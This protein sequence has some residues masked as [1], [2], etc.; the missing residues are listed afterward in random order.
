MS[1]THNKIAREDIELFSTCPPSNAVDRSNYIRR[2]IEAAR[3]S[4]RYGAKGI[5]VYT[6]NALI[7]PWLVA[8]LIVQ[9]TESQCPLIAVQPVYMHPYT[10]AKVVTSFGYLYGRRVYLNMVAGG[11]KNDLVALTDTTPHDRRYD[12][13]VEYTLIIKK[14]LTGPS[15]VSYDGEFYK[16]DNLTLTPL[17]HPDLFPRIF[18][19][20]S[21]EAGLAAAKAIDAVAVEYPKP[22]RE[23]QDRVLDDGIEHGIRVGIIARASTDDAW[24]VAKARFPEDR[25]GQLTHQLAMKVSDSI[26]HKQLSQMDEEKANNPYWLGPFHNYKTFCPYLVGSYS[27]VAAELSRYI[28][29]GYHAFILDIPPSEDEL[30]HTNMAFT[31]AVEQVAT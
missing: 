30:F 14:L 29:A 13:L 9:H 5:L 31:Q 26:W 21:S 20:G 6:D 18:V 3:W 28:T 2:V 4:E 7:D 24:A 1:T 16:V 8:Q 25:K 17:L 22:A 27:Q 11:F 15:A 12:R 23:Y 10:V 19:S